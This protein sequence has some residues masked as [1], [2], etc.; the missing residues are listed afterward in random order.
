MHTKFIYQTVKYKATNYVIIFSYNLKT[1]L[2]F[3]YVL[4]FYFDECLK[5]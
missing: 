5:G 1:L 2:H 4:H 3:V